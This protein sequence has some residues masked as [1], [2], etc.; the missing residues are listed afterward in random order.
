MTFLVITIHWRYLMSVL[1]GKRPGIAL[2]GA[3]LA[4]MSVTAAG[5]AVASAAPSRPSGAS[6]G[7]TKTVA[8]VSDQPL[9]TTRP[10]AVRALPA[11]AQATLAGGKVRPA[12]ATPRGYLL[13]GGGPNSG[14]PDYRYDSAYVWAIEASCGLFECD[15]IQQ[16]RLRLTENVAGTNSK[17]WSLVLQAQPWS[18]PSIYSLSYDYECGV[19]IPDAIDQTCSTW[20]DDNA[21]GPESADAYDGYIINKNFGDTSNVTKFPMVNMKV[22]FAD[23]SVAIGDDGQ[24]GEKFRGWDVCV[25]ARSTKL[26]PSTGTGA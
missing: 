6:D 2:L 8:F 20:R 24:N 9:T 10:V 13:R 18:G 3:V 25:K 21:D 17:R 15:V 12:D 4:A 11:Q 16:V 14:N 19:N 7:A 22:E 26:C 1:R 5:T 23:G